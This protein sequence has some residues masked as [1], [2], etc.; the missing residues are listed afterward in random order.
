MLKAADQ[1]AAK[2]ESKKNEAV[3]MVESLINSGMSAH[4]ILEKLK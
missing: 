3:G 1:G 2:L 4:E